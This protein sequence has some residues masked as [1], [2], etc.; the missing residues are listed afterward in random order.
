MSF[1]PL[2]FSEGEEDRRAKKKIS[3]EIVVFKNKIVARLP[4]IFLVVT[5]ITHIEG[6]EKF[7]NCCQKDL[8]IKCEF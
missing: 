8:L 5:L 2:T 3:I 1:F 7:F 4:T 6:G